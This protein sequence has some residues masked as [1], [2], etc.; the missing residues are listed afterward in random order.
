MTNAIILK[1][2]KLP[3]IVG[4][5]THSIQ[6]LK[7]F[8]LSALGVCL[9][10]VFVLLLVVEKP[11]VVL[12]LTPEAI[13]QRVIEPPKA[14]TQVRTAVLRYIE[15]RY[16]WEPSTV[17][18]RLKETQAFILPQN[19]KGFQSSLSEVS[20]FSIDK[21]VSQR[22]YP[23]EVQVDLAKK[24]V[25]VTGDRVSSIQGLKAAG[26]LK[27]AL[28]FEGGPHTPENPWGLYITKEREE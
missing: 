27:L 16:N 1:T 19:L 25:F 24:T 3:R 11:P 22:A 18:Q 5:L 13:P 26:D 8:S 9:G 7:I 28:S 14:E 2:S 10:L 15:K 6:F 21:Q 12:T 20:R 4:E 23:V 17:I